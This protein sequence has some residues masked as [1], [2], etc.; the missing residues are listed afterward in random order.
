MT[1]QNEN[2]AGLLQCYEGQRTQ[3][4]RFLVARSGD[5]AEAEDLLQDLWLRLQSVKPGPVANPRAYLFQM[6]NNLVLDRVR[7]RRRRV[8]R[9]HSFA[10]NTHGAI[11]GEVASAD[12]EPVEALI[13]AEELRELRQ[14]VA[15][16][17]EGARRAFCLH[18][19]EG[20]SHG[21]VAARLNISR[22]GVEKHIAVAMKH[23]RRL[24]QD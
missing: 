21:E 17:P 10:E 4:L 12:P 15:S 6:A 8:L 2:S 11:A 20:L 13:E 9:D 22:S 14:A 7:E 24:L 23:L 16:L 5:A 1:Q 19:L 3:L 18:K